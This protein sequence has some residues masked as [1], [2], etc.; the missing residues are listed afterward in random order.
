MSVTITLMATTVRNVQEDIMVMLQ[1][2]RSM[3]VRHV[4]VQKE[5]HVTWYQLYRKAQKTL[6]VRSVL[7]EG[8]VKGI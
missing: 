6:Y 8:E 4:L 7:K 1:M 3:I 5:V 2:E